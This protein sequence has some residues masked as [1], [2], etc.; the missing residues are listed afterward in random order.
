[1]KYCYE[2]NREY[3]DIC[4]FCEEEYQPPLK[5]KNANDLIVEKF[6]QSQ[7]KENSNNENQRNKS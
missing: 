5:G 6:N 1:M 3:N 4:R 7:R 2:H